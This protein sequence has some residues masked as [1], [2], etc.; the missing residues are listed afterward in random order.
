MVKMQHL[1]KN[2][3]NSSLG[4]SLESFV[5]K[6][7]CY[8]LLLRLREFIVSLWYYINSLLIDK[9]TKMILF[10]SALLS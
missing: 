9:E 3:E 4:Q 10:K 2:F 5:F 6:D 1:L 8:T 7:M